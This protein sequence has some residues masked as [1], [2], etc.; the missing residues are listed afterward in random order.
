MGL[1]STYKH[2]NIPWYDAR[3]QTPVERSFKKKQDISIKLRK[4][5]WLLGI[6][7]ELSLH[8]WLVLYK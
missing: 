6:K 4:M 3:C 5:Y 2:G 7:S 1:D 8:K